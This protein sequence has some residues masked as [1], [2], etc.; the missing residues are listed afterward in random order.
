MAFVYDRFDIAE[1]AQKCGIEFYPRQK[2]PVELRANCP[3]CGDTKFHFGLNREKEMFHCFRCKAHGNSV[4]LYAKLHGIS[5][6][7][8]YMVLQSELD[9]RNFVLPTV[10]T[11][12][13]TPI[14][15][16]AERHD[17]YYDF[18][19]LLK[20]QPVHRENLMNR[21]LEFSEIHR[22]LYKSV[23]LDHVFRREVLE[24][25]SAMH[26]LTGIPGFYRDGNG[27]W[28]M[29]FKSCGGMFVPVCD[30]NGYIQGLQMRLDLPEDSKEK[31]F[32][33]FSS[34]YFEGGT[35][36]KSWIHV[37]GDT[38]S[39][40]VILTEGA[41][42]ADIASVL[43]NGR[44]FIAVPGVNAVHLL[45]DVLRDLK[46]RKVYEAWDMDK[47][48]KAEVKNAL[49]SLR[50][51]MESCGIAYKGCSWN[52]Y[53]KGIDDYCLAKMQVSLQAA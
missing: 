22:F 24:K 45:P 48:S 13:Q 10:K 21:G 50:A 16:L 27:D 52:P 34:K 37:I 47:Y 31:K 30:K 20:L 5:N 4:S 6:R 36:A 12:L 7:E 1:V 46:I 28:Q 38:S 42:K 44:L 53:Y 8:A 11:D 25:L 2:N 3:F 23:P 49:I 41:M 39:D 14:R 51:L 29:Y 43:S 35:A 33:W 18:L 32:R 15:P 26:D 40:E 9:E 19:Q 17:V